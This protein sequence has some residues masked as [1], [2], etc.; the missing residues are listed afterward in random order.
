M[1]NRTGIETADFTWNL[2][3]GCLNGCSFCYARKLA[4][5]WLKD[6]Y[7]RN[8]NTSPLAPAGVD[9]TDPFFPRFW[10]NRRGDPFTV[11][12][13]FK[14]SNPS[15]R[16]GTAMIFAIDMGDI[17]GSSIPADWIWDLMGTIEECPQ[18]FQILTKFP[19]T[20]LYW[21]AAHGLP[22][23]VWAG[24]TVC[25]QSMVAPAVDCLSGIDAAVKYVCVEPLQERIVMELSGVDWMIIGAQTNP[26]V[27]PQ[28]EWVE[29]LLE[30][31]EE[32]GTKVF[33]KKS[34][35][36]HED[37]HEWPEHEGRWKL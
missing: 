37:I 22:E 7:L 12:E 26:L 25:N 34:L 23:N 1:L 8:E 16:R 10:R 27:L 17:F 28:R 31:A 35:N 32:S 6:T 13:T 29:T 14:S 3:T 36:W 11:P 9:K 18:V 5:G 20:L 2:Y 24:V 15:L 4:R 21:A 30:E 33:L 19:G